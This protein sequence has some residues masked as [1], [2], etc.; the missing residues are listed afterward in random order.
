MGRRVLVL[1]EIIAILR[2][3]GAS[4]A[5][6]DK[7]TD[8]VSLVIGAKPTRAVDDVTVGSGFGQ[9][10]ERGF[11]ELTLNDERSQMD[12]RKAKE[13]GLMLIEAAE[14]AQSDEMFIQL[15][16]RV[17]L[18]DAEARGR[19]LIELREIRQGSRGVV[20]PQ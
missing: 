16:S 4:P 7:F 10:S 15:L 1:E 19:F 11:V 13:I 17:G 12:A 18:D 8:Q 5:V 20:R 9:K 2:T 14:A 6:I 3:V